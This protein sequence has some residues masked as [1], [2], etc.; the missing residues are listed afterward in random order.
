[1]L[2]SGVCLVKADF[3]RQFFQLI[4][5]QQ[6]LTLDHRDVVHYLLLTPGWGPAF[7]GR[8]L[9]QVIGQFNFQAVQLTDQPRPLFLS[10]TSTHLLVTTNW[11]SIPT[12]SNPCKFLRICIA[13]SLWPIF[14]DKLSSGHY[15]YYVSFIRRSRRGKFTYLAEVESVRVGKKVVQRF[16]RYIGLEEDGKTVLSCSV[17]LA[18]VEEVK[19]AG[20][21]M[22][23]HALR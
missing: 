13:G 14:L 22:M 3:R 16:S 12:S 23:L 17:S 8:R 15:D 10:P 19:L 20:P 11:S 1:M 2:F 7:F 5:R 21:L 4:I 9:K 6:N 18:S